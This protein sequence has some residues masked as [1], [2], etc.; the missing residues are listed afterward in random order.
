VD[1]TNEDISLTR[2]RIRHR[3]VPILLREFGTQVGRILVRES[4]LMNELDDYLSRE[5]DRL[6]RDLT[7][8][9]PSPEA[10]LRLSLPR[11]R[12]LEPV[13]QRSVIR[14]ALEGLLGGLE[15]IHLGH[16]DAVLEAA[17]GEDGSTSL[18]LPRGIRITREY[19][20]LWIGLPGEDVGRGRPEAS[21]PLAVGRPDSLRW[22][23]IRLEWRVSPASGLDPSAWA[24][25]PDRACFDL[26]ALATPAYV[27]G[28]REGDRMEPFGMEGSQKISDLLIDRKVPRTLRT[29]VAL[30]CDNGGPARGERILWVVG[31]RRAR[32]APVGPGSSQVVLFEAETIV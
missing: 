16:V 29:R 12:G 18:D 9:A 6:L 20:S 25:R 8:T 15:E 28:V 24:D 11:F 17:R 10:G 3:L 7:G 31:Q 13:L 26:D 1:S 2:N 21:A 32:H 5:S 22:G 30:L 27:R 14:A 4:Q 19:D 23:G